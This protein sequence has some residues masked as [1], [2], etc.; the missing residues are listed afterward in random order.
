MSGD[1]KIVVIYFDTDIGVHFHILIAITSVGCCHGILI[2]NSILFINQP[3]SDREFIPDK[4]SP[5]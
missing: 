1:L 4:E 5:V 3:N 2:C